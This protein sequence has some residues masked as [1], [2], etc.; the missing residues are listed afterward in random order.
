MIAWIVIGT[1]C[2]FS[3]RRSAV[4]VTS[5]SSVPVV[6]VAVIGRGR[7]DNRGTGCTQDR[8]Y[9]RRNLRICLHRA[10]PRGVGDFPTRTH[11]AIPGGGSQDTR[12]YHSPTQGA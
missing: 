9:G 6:A 3:T 7:K 10:V 2:R 4:T 8:G 5:C 11:S 12:L 1:S